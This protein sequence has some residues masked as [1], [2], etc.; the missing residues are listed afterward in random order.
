MA[1]DAGAT[2]RRVSKRGDVSWRSR[3]IV[4]GEGLAGE[5]VRIEETQARLCVYY[6]WKQVRAIPL[7]ALARAQGREHL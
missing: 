5:E 1:Y 3:R 7:D 2:L 6:S 4:V